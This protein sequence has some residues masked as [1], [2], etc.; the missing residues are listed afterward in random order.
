MSPD[1]KKTAAASRALEFVKPGMVI[2]LG[3]GSTAAAFVDLLGEKVADGFEIT[4]V[5]TSLATERQAQARG[6]PLTSLDNQLLLDLTID[7]ADEID[8]QLRLI[9]G[10]GGALLREKIVAA[11]SDALIIIAD[12]SKLVTTLGRFPLPVEVVTFGLGATQR[13]ISALAHELD[14]D[15]EIA[16]RKTETGETF[17]TDSNHAIFDCSFSEIPDPETLADFLG[18]VPG[19]VEHGL[20]LEFADMAIIAGSDGVTVLEADYDDEAPLTV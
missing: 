16:L 4:G 17:T 13:M 10:G 12:D 7:G 6:I 9:K 1:E 19:V 11:A 20:F 15:G 18:A 3:T 2:G 14:L 5:P 8:D